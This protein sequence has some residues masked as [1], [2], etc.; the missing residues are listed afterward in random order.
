MIYHNALSSDMVDKWDLISRIKHFAIIE[1][2]IIAKIE[3][4]PETFELLIKVSI[5]LLIHRWMS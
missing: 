5:D 4:L 1:Y 3:D 2:K